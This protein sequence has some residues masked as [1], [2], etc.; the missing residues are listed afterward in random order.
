MKALT[1]ATT[2]IIAGVAA[3]LLTVSAASAAAP[4]D[5]ATG[6]FVGKGSVQS[7][8]GERVTAEVAAQI[9][10]ELDAHATYTIECTFEAGRNTQTVYRSGSATLTDEAVTSEAR[11]NKNDN[12]TGFLLGAADIDWATS[13]PSVGDW[14]AGGRFGGTITDVV[15]LDTSY[16][17]SA[18]YGGEKYTLN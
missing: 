4:Y 11:T 18:V 3:A 9:E 17:L 5:P 1:R 16:T 13:I 6:G 10:F 15:D 8:I 14:C 12:V 7:V 2:G